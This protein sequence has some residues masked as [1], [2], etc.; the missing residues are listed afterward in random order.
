MSDSTGTTTKVL[1]IGGSYAGL[2][3]VRAIVTKWEENIKDKD[4]RLSVSFVEPR[5]GFLNIL[6]IPKTIVDL[7]FAET[8]YVPFEVIDLKF[9]KV[10]SN[11]TEVIDRIK[12]AATGSNIDIEY[13]QGRVTNLEEYE[14]TYELTGVNSDKEVTSGKI[15]FD[16]AMVATGRDRKWPVTPEALTPKSFIADMQKFKTEIEDKSII[17][18]I[19]AGAVGIELAGDIKHHMPE[20]TVQLIH[21]HESFPPEPLSDEFKSLVH[22]NLSETGGVVTVLNTRI[23]KELENGDLL[24]TTGETIK[25]DINYW[26]TNHR[27]NTDIFCEELSKEFVNENNNVLV[28]EYLQLTNAT[29]LIGHIFVLGD[30]VELP[31]IKSAGWAMYMGRQAANNIV[32]LITESKLVEPFPNL[33][34]MPKGMVVVAGKGHIV[35]EL[36]NVVE[37]DNQEYVNEYKDYCLG[38]IRA[39]LNI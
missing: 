13:I 17:T 7:E 34:K 16:Y 3:A 31:L 14:A 35:S 24:T 27:N 38:K 5:S 12:T 20:K 19:G 21:P 1:I 8:Q 23:S 11:D 9:S 36:W 28:N 4:Q 10:V 37:L 33:E 29:K 22:E 15:S 18:I 30:L 25:S 6:G 39:T 32:G 26:C 2:S